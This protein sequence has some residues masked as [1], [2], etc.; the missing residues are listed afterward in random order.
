MSQRPGAAAR[1]RPAGHWVLLG[2]VLLALVAALLLQGYAD[3]EI[4]G[5]G[6]APPLT[7]G[8][9][10][11]IAGDGAVVYRDGDTMASRDLPAKTVALTFDDGPDPR[12]TPKILDV[13]R[14]EHVPGTFFDVGTRIARHPGLVRRE[15]AEGHEVGNHT[16]AHNSLTGI[17]RWRGN[18]EV[19]LTQLALAGATGRTS[20]IL[21]PPYSAT[22]AALEGP[23]LA[24][25]Q[26]EVRAGYLVV[27]TNL[28]SEDW[29]RPGWIDIVANSTPTDGAG[30]IVLMHDA[31]G[32]RSQTVEAL[33][34][35]I[36]LLKGRGYR[37]TTVTG[38]LGLP[39]GA[40]DQHVTTL[41]HWQGLTF[42][43]LL[44]LSNLVATALLWLLIPLGVLAVLRSVVLIAFAR[45]HA[46]T[47]WTRTQA[48]TFL[49]P[50]TIVVPAYNE[51]V[52]IE[53]A[54]RSLAASDYPV[55]EVVVVDDG[56]DDGTADLVEALGLPEVRVMRQP[57]Q[58]KAV[59]LNT[60]VSVAR[61][62]ILVMVDGD[63]VFQPDTVRWLVQP[64]QDERVGAVSGNTKVGN[65]KGLLG[66]WQHLEYVVGFNLDRRM[67]DL[68]LC[69]P[70]VP[71]AIG[72]FR[73]TALQ[74][75][76]GVS[77][78]T[79]AEDTDLTM[80]VNRAGFRVVYEERAL[81]WTEAPAS[82]NALWRQ[83]YRWCYGTLQSVWK[84]RGAVRDRGQGRRLGRVG[85]PYLLAFQVGLP[86]L[87]PIVDVFALYGLL[88][89]SPW[90]VV[91]YW[92]GFLVLQIIVSAYAL[93]LDRETLRPLWSLPLQQLVYRQLMYLVVIHS[94]VSA[95]SGVRLHW[96]KLERT[97]DLTLPARN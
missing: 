76:G 4:G 17:A 48:G 50:V 83:R 66:R 44:S 7:S 89:L 19:S 92:G 84:H 30:A 26:R 1:R 12:W 28:D 94:L 80:A 10:A 81:A 8:A 75:V 40:A 46:R 97:G 16:F 78:D 22:P 34:R 91:A 96:H 15:L 36:E 56:S 72:A 41:E 67:Y 38:G 2:V 77:T 13:L 32:D 71:G 24:A 5:S 65:R 27:L 69:M 11:H 54:V 58:G 93:R 64:F 86:L 45:H 74:V 85:L 90:R 39:A 37:F 6:T 33:P 87:A 47:A 73:R 18:L 31:G 61:H 21:R 70:T 53:R 20:A 49:P 14:S 79:L 51:A 59:A 63:T 52:G 25:T 88:F 43:W 23:D 35:L 57:N 62:D 9:T 29:R 55:L 42:L 68:L 60:G 82:L 95:A 3:H